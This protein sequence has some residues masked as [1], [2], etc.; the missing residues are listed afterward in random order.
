MSMKLRPLSTVALITT[1]LFWA[2]EPDLG[3]LSSKYDP[4]ASGAGGTTPSSG[5]SAG[6]SGTS[7]KGGTGGEITA[8]GTGGDFPI[9][10]SGDEAGAAGEAPLGGGTGGTSGAGGTS[11]T[12][13]SS[14]Q[15]SCS[16]GKRD[17]NESDVDCGGSKCDPCA[18][19]LRCGTNDDCDSNYCSKGRCTDPTCRDGVQNQHETGVDCGGECDGCPDDVACTTN[20]DC[21]GDYCKDSVCTDHCTSMLKDADETDKDCGGADC[22]ACDTGKHCLVAKDC[23]SFVCSNN[24]CQAATCSDGVAN[25]GEGDVDC[26]AVCA[27]EGKWCSATRH[28]SC[29]LANDCDSSICTAGA[30][31]PPEEPLPTDDVIDDFEAHSGNMILPSGPITNPRAGNWYGYNDGT[32]MATPPAQTTAIE[33]IPGHRGVNSSWGLHTAGSGFTS[34]GAGIGADLNN[35]GTGGKEPYDASYDDGSGTMVPY[36]GIT[37][38]ARSDTA[39]QTVSVVFPDGDTDSAGGICTTCDHHWLGSVII[40]SDWQQFTVPFS[41]LQLE[42]GTQPPPGPFDPTRLVSVQFR[43]NP[44]PA[45]DF[46]VDDVAFVRPQ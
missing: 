14:T 40:G 13:G 6:V 36:A 26:G 12:G 23:A 20:D 7:A 38:W 24:K 17:S 8:G 19:G 43:V 25:Q 39:P 44:G 21:A 5:G 1:A 31:G 45:F 15:S 34:W 10:G 11:G 27:G 35:S 18:S 41:S 29:V 3:N 4:N 28:Q 22:A 9:G 32:S 30:C 33:L 2:C 16:N 37:F 42:S 46:W